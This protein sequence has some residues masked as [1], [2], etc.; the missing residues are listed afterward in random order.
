MLTRQKIPITDVNIIKII[1][2]YNLDYTKLE[3][4]IPPTN[5]F[6]GI[7]EQFL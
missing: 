4:S 2:Q 5:K 3:G 7:L 6:V 1:Q